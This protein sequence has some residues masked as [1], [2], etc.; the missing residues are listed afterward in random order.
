M[1]G[2]NKAVIPVGKPDLPVST[3]VRGHH[4]SLVPLNGPNVAALDNDFH[5]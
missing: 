2:D 3:G 4:R 1:S 5:V